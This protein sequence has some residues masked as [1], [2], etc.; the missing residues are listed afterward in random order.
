VL[1]VPPVERHQGLLE[2]RDQPEPDGAALVEQILL[3]R[4]GLALWLLDLGLVEFGLG[5]G[6]PAQ[7]VGVGAQQPQRG[8]LLGADRKPLLKQLDD[9]QV[10]FADVE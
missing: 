8:G 3:G 6:Q 1:A 7:G 2:Q 4:S 10:V 9:D 5:L